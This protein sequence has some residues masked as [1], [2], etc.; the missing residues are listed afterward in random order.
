MVRFRVYLEGRADRIFDALNVGC[1]G[2]RIGDDRAEK[3]L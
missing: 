3:H 1:E 2:K